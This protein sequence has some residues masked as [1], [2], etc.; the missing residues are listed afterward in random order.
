[1]ASGTAL[2]VVNWVG[3]S[4]SIV[5]FAA[6]AW[7]RFFIVRSIGLDDLLM[8]I[9]LLASLAAA[10]LIT[11]SVHYGMGSETEGSILAS[12]YSFLSGI[13]VLIAQA[14]GRISF[15]FTLLSILGITMVRRWFLFAIIGLQVVF[16]V[17][18]LAL[19][20]GLCSP[21]SVFWNSTLP[22]A[23]VCLAKYHTVVVDGWNYFQTAWDVL[24]D[25]SLALFPALIF[26]SMNMQMRLKIG[27]IILMG[28]GVLTG[29]CAIV[30]SVEF[31]SLFSNTK[32]SNY[33]QATIFIWTV[34]QQ[35]IVII[36]SSVPYCLCL[37]RKQG[38]RTIGSSNQ[39]GAYTY[40]RI[41]LKPK[42]YKHQAE[43]LSRQNFIQL[44]SQK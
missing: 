6:R 26:K 41:T 28:L 22:E 34:V 36:A 2:N 38:N 16:L 40:G 7:T 33:A 30:K 44:D 8:F 29:I 5:V 39:T 24:T 31:A 15:A 1:M 43:D 20:Y 18:D 32:N 25:F 21:V 13:P 9:S 4:L 23:Q 19:S 3:A 37:F 35:Y 10:G 11:A 14:I 42:P 27:M 17:V 12:K